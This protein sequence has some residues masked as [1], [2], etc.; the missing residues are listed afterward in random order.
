MSEYLLCE[1]AHFF[2][3]FF[4]IIESPFKVIIVVHLRALRTMSCIGPSYFLHLYLSVRVLFKAA[5]NQL[6]TVF[7]VVKLT[8]G[9]VR[10][11]VQ[12]RPCSL[13]GLVLLPPCEVLVFLVLIS[14]PLP[15]G[16]PCCVPLLWA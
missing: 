4:Q 9:V 6:G 10:G 14:E 13:G 11:C 1:K 2:V 7:P 5:V 16:S 15:V 8:S 3:V 12:D